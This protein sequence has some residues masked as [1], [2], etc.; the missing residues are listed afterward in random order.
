MLDSYDL[1]F[2]DNLF[3]CLDRYCLNYCFCLGNYNFFG[4]FFDYFFS[5]Y[6]FFGNFFNNLFFN[7]NLY[8]NF[9]DNFLLNYDLF[10]YLPEDFLFHHDR[11]GGGAATSGCYRKN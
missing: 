6:Y 3:D 10:L 1:F 9:L 7:H 8:W 5:D 4:N 2:Y 11:R